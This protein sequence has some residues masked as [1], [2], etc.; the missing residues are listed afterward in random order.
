M[1]RTGYRDVESSQISEKSQSS[2]NRC[3][4]KVIRSDTVKDYNTF[5][6][7]LISIHTIYVQVFLFAVKCVLILVALCAQKPDLALV[8]RDNTYLLHY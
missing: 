5:F 7:S 6:L 8:R 3:T 2:M 1:L 4:Y